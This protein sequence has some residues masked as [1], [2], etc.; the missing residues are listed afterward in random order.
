MD[1]VPSPTA[2]AGNGSSPILDGAGQNE[3]ACALTGGG[4]RA[5]SG[6]RHRVG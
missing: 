5:R 4:A 2:N 6:E 3:D 1:E